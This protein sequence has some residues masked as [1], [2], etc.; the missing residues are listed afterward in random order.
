MRYRRGPARAASA[1]RRRSSA[2][3]TPNWRGRGVAATINPVE[4]DWPERGGSVR[5]PEPRTASG[6]V[7]DEL[8]AI[9]DLAWVA[10]LDP[11][12]SRDSSRT[13]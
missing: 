4:D 13:R 6:E 10:T 8:L 3:A 12:A 11:Y 7:R 9:H 2:N 1:A 5:V